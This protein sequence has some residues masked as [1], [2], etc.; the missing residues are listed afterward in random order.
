MEIAA[1]LVVSEKKEAKK[2]KVREIGKLQ[3]FRWVRKTNEESGGGEQGRQHETNELRVDPSGE[4]WNLYKEFAL[5]VG[6]FF[7][8]Y[9]NQRVD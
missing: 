3:A 4:P 6:K 7:A 1:A 2:R 9:P 5:A 8:R